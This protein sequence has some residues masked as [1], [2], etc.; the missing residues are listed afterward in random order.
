MKF[1]KEA[2]CKTRAS[3]KY[4][5]RSLKIRKKVNPIYRNNTVKY[6]SDILLQNSLV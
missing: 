3:S 4:R 2:I 1:T 5:K 6:T